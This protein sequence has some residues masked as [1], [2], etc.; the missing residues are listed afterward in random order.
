MQGLEFDPERTIAS[1]IK[2]HCLLDHAATVGTAKQN[3]LA[4]V[5]FRAYFAD[6][7]L[8]SSKD[9]LL[10]AAEKVTESYFIISRTFCFQ[11]SKQWRIRDFWE[12]EA[13]STESN[14]CTV[15]LACLTKSIS[16]PK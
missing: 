15:T 7:K 16:A 10:A 9:F 6:G 12:E 5:L 2:S 4:E 3:E 14:S 13:Q 11:C 1:T 8:I